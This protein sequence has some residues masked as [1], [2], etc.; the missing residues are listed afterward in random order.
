MENNNDIKY[1][2]IDITIKNTDGF[3]VGLDLKP[4]EQNKGFYVG[5]TN[6]KN[7][8]I[9][10][11]VEKVLK[12]KDKTQFKQI[13]NKL[14]FGGWKDSKTLNYYVDLSIHIDSLKYAVMVARLFNQKAI[15]DIKNMQSIYL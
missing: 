9:I 14:C 13:K 4:Q 8:D 1:K 11:A 10:K 12:Q 5:L 15:F 3:T 6:N 2:L 7:K